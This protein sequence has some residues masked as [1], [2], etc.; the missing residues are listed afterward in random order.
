MHI[1]LRRIG[2]VYL[3]TATHAPNTTVRFSNTSNAPELL[4]VWDIIPGAETANPMWVALSQSAPFATT[5]TPQNLFPTDPGLPGVLSHGSLAAAIVPIWSVPAGGGF[6]P[7]FN[8]IWP[9]AVLPP[10]WSVDVQ[11]DG[12]GGVAI[13]AAFFFEAILTDY[14]DLLYGS[15]ERLT[16]GS[17]KLP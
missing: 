2:R 5:V 12:A 14:F 6:A 17:G 8:R 3:E 13:G 1:N 9:F 16:T 10:G 11:N 7:G 4:I 15:Y